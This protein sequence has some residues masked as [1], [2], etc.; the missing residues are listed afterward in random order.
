MF[1]L[2][3]S[4]VSWDLQTW[5]LG[6]GLLGGSSDL[7]PRLLGV[8]A[9]Q[10]WQLGVSW[11]FRTRQLGIESSGFQPSL[12][13]SDLTPRIWK[14]WISAWFLEIFRLDTSGWLVWLSSEILLLKSSCLRMSPATFSI[15]LRCWGKKFLYKGIQKCSKA[16]LPGSKRGEGTDQNSIA[17]PQILQ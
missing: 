1:E 16:A 11:D 15:W 17:F 12:R 14:F 8:W 10:T 9:V 6:L 5:E 3:T 13:S 7:G 4:E 2:N